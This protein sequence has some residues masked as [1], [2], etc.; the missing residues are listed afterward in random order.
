MSARQNRLNEEIGFL[1]QYMQTLEKNTDMSNP[2][3]L[4][5]LNTTLGYVTACV[6][7]RTSQLADLDTAMEDMLA[8]LRKNPT[9]WGLE[10]AYRHIDLASDVCPEIVK[11]KERVEAISRRIKPPTDEIKKELVPCH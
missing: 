6:A 11:Y 8:D 5:A 10:L 3:A 1:T 2:L 9:Q 4:S 7:N